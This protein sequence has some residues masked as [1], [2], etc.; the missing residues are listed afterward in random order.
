MRYAAADTKVWLT[1]SSSPSRFYFIEQSPD[2]TQG[3]WT[4]SGLGM[5]D[6]AGTATTRAFVNP[7]TSARFFRIRAVR[8]LQQ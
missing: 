5:I 8:P 7:D 6:P 1:W 3:N 4:D 2:S